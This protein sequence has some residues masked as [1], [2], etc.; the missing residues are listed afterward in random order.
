MHVNKFHLLII[1]IIVF[2]IFAIRTRSTLANATLESDYVKELH[3][4]LATI[5][6]Y[7]MCVTSGFL[8]WNPDIA[9]NIW[10]SVGNTLLSVLSAYAFYKTNPNDRPARYTWNFIYLFFAS[11]LM[12]EIWEYLGLREQTINGAS[13]VIGMFVVDALLYTKS[14][15]KRLAFFYVALTVASGLLAYV[16]A[17][18]SE[19]LCFALNGLYGMAVLLWMYYD[20]DRIADDP[21]RYHLDDAL[22]YFYDFEGM[23][24]RYWNKKN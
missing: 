10:F 1:Y 9:K 24:V 11:I 15:R 7:H 12:G 18:S 6:C 5:M 14:R 20:H 19:A 2:F 22:K 21:T 3:Q 17:G 8:Y 13:L 16:F 23:V 4:V